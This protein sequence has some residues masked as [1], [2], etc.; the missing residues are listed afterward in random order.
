LVLHRLAEREQALA[1]VLGPTHLD[2]AALAERGG[3]ALGALHGAPCPVAV[4]PAGYARRIPAPPR[5]L[6]VAWDGSAEADAALAAAVALAERDD[7]SVRILHA[8]QPATASE[9]TRRAAGSAVAD[10]PDDLVRLRQAAA[11]A[12]LRVPVE[13]VLVEEAAELGLVEATRDLELLVMGS[14]GHGPVKRRRWRSVS[15]SLVRR[16]ACPVLIVPRGA[17][18]AVS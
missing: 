11:A 4:A 15:E 14:R 8:A 10:Q 17:R 7:G 9:Q 16:S 5:D 2:A 1:L 6:G 12:G 3:T 13:T 18:V